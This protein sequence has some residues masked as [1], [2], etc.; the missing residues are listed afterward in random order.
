MAGFGD[1]LLSGLETGSAMRKRAAEATRIADENAQR[2]ADTDAR[3]AKTNEKPKFGNYMDG[4]SLDWSTSQGTNKYGGAFQQP[5]AGTPTAP[6]AAPVAAAIP[7]GA[8][9]A[10]AASAGVPAAVAAPTAPVAPSSAGGPA[11]IPSAPGSGAARSVNPTWEAAKAAGGAIAD[12]AGWLYNNLPRRADG[13]RVDFEAEPQQPYDQPPVQAAPPPA[14]A[15]PAA[16]PAFGQTPNTES[17]PTQMLQPEGA[18][19]DRAQYREDYSKWRDEM[20]SIIYTQTGDYGKVGQFREAENNQL[21]EQTLGY[22]SGALFAAA[23]GDTANATRLM[24]DAMAMQPFDTGMEWGTDGRGM[25]VMDD[26]GER[27]PVSPR[28]LAEFQRKLTATPEN[29]N[30]FLKEERAIDLHGAT[31]DQM[32]ADTEWKSQSARA[33]AAETDYLL[34]HGMTPAAAA[35]MAKSGYGSGV[36]EGELQ[37]D[38]IKMMLDPAAWGN[39]EMAGYLSQLN[40]TER[41]GLSAR[42]GRYARDTGKNITQATAELVAAEANARSQAGAQ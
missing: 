2:K 8:P 15:I 9:A 24:N 35:A 4:G 33:S 17:P 7:V 6:V 39:P 31:K 16:E 20:E 36:K 14:A 38:V 25:F 3:A 42:A 23:R 40:Q 32:N 18:M 12:G 10:A 26:K 1:G 13:G 29:Y 21:R 34:R 28:E 30:E 27:R 19:P 11:G 5:A 22:T 37:L 41:L